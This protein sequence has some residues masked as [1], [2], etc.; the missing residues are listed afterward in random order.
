MSERGPRNTNSVYPKYHGP[1]NSFK[2]LQEV[3]N[4]ARGMALW[5]KALVVF[6]E[7]QVQ[8]SH[9]SYGSS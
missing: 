8:N 7:D 9:H 5:L 3:Q 2:K 1:G 4:K 6:P